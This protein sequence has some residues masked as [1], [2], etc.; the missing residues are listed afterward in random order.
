[1][2]RNRLRQRLAV[3]AG[4]MLLVLGSVGSATA[5]PQTRTIGL[6]YQGETTSD[7]GYDFDVSGVCDDC[8]PGVFETLL[9]GGRWAYGATA[10]GR[11]NHVAWQAA[12]STALNYDDALLRQGQ[13]LGLSDVLT[14]TGGAIVATGK[15]EGSAGLLVDPTGGTNFGPSGASDDIDK[16]ATW[17]ASCAMPLPGDGARLCVSD[18]QDIQ[19][20]SRAVAGTVLTGTLNLVLS[21]QLRLEFTV[22]SDGIIAT[23]AVTFTG[24]SGSLNRSLAFV[25]ATPSTL[26]DP[27]ALSCTQPSGADV[28][29]SLQA[30]PYAPTTNVAGRGTLHAAA[31]IKFPLLDPIEVVGSDITSITAPTHAVPLALTGNAGS[32]TLGAL[33]KNNIPPTPDS[34]GGASHEYSGDQGTPITFDG[35]A[36]SSPC[37]FPTL[38]W[39]F[40]DGGVAFGAKPKHTF[41]GSGTYSGLL[42]ATD[43]TGLTATQTFSVEIFNQAPL[44][45]AGLDT[46][47]AWG[48]SVAFTGQAVDP[49]TDD[50]STLTYWWRFGDGTPDATGSGPSV[51]H[52]YAAPSPVNEPYTAMLTVCDRHGACQFDT[53]LVTIRARDV[54]VGAVGDTAATFDTGARLRASLVDEF[55]QAVNGRTVSFAVET[56][57]GASGS[58]VTSSTGLASTAWT[59]GLA[60]GSYGITASFAGDTFYSAASGG[61]NVSIARKAT[62]TAYTGTLTGGAN[63]TVTLSATLVDA[64]GTPLAGRTIAFKLGAQTTSAVTS[65]SG[66]ASVQLKLTQKNGTYPL[67]ATWT[68]AGSDAAR[69]LPSAASATFKLQAK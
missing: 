34:G 6:A 32:A 14:P 46:I 29:Y 15:I 7:L 50:Q 55:G 47:A 35:S 26:A 31:A 57:P 30:D 66:V 8:V 11:V 36:S 43:V 20:A 13:T 68:P 45:D 21:I 12:T 16:N 10:T 37:G 59:P 49:G 56:V 17:T 60:A 52:A 63:K 18:T 4:G 48:R 9:G 23:R 65:A 19:L 33:A 58:A 3:L 62:T 41:Q 69:Y 67:T 5:A 42:T 64:T 25:G 24:G 38:R 54:S 28:V 1:M 2:I 39:D 22:S 61:G 53:R 51:T 44:V 27:I 40:S